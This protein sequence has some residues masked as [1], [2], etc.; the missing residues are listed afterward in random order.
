MAYRYEK[1]ANNQQDL[2]IDGWSKGI[3]S[4]PFTGIGN[5]RNLNI[6]YYDGVAYVNY[7]RQACTITGGTLANPLWATQSPAG[8]IYI[9]DDN[10]QIWKQSAVNSST[11]ALLTGNFAQAISG[12]QF[13]NNYLFVF[14]SGTGTSRLEICGDGTGDAGV[15]SSNWNTPLVSVNVTITIATPAVFTSTGHGLYAGQ[16]IRFY[17][18]GALPTGLTA[19]TNYY[20]S[21]TSLTTD[22]FKVA[23]TYANAIAGTPVVNTSGSQSGVQTYQVM[24]AGGWPIRNITSNASFTTTPLVGATSATISTVPDA[25][26]VS[27]DVWGM[28]SGIYTLLIPLADSTTQS[29]VASFTEGSPDVSWQPALNANAASSSFQTRWSNGTNHMSLNTANTGDV[30]FCNGAYIGALQLPQNQIFSKINPLTFRFSSDSLELPPADTSVWLMELQSQLIVMGQFR[31]YPWNFNASRYNSPVPMDE[32]LVKGINI[33]NKLYIFAGNKGNIY[34]SNG[35][36]VSRYTKLPDYIAGVVDPS[37]T[38]GG[39]MQHR[40]KLYFQA[41]AKN[42]QTNAVVY[43]GIFSLDLDTGALNMEN[44]NSGG[45]TPTGMLTT[46]VLI[47]DNSTAINYDKYYS[48]FGAT[49]PKIDFNDTTLYSSSEAVIETDIIP[50]GTFLQNKTFTSAEFKLDQPLQSGDSISLYARQS[51]ADT[52]TLIGTTNAAV[53]S[54]STQKWPFEK[55]QWVQFKVTMSCNATATS[56]S[57]NR[58]REIRL[59]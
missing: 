22:T 2:V 23:T 30:Y 19:D 31:L 25:N 9:S 4:S 29:V 38:I 33:L 49:A 28:P 54:D 10:Q 32:A 21:A 46:G 45:L 57:F 15:T 1:N 48:A 26:N 3:A 27:R 50:I 51:L 35:Y 16:P 12:L 36:S 17:T 53:L 44:Q 20:V 18:T 52:F 58:L 47:D 13:W 6:K 42:G 14:G 24:R 5:I 7:K 56:S 37:W 39:Q 8:L 59:R 43:A 34:T 55:W 11:F 41:V 40:Q